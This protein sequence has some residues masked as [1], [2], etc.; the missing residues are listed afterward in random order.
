LKIPYRFFRHPGQVHSLEQAA[1]ERGQLPGQVVRSIVFRTGQDEFVMAL[2]AG[3]KQI[4]WPALRAHLGQSRMTMATPDEVLRVTGYHTGSVS[5]FGLPQ[6]IRILV[7]ES[8]LAHPEVSIGSGLRNTT[9][10]I[11]TD[12]LLKALGDVEMAQLG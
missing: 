6:A 9:V 7:D 11:K 10:I 3:P 12:D 2:V 8:V 4:S 1:A 5:P